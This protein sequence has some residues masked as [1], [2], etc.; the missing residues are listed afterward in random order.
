M[1]GFPNIIDTAEIDEQNVVI[2]KI[3]GENLR[4]VKE[5]QID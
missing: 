2:M 5:K 1:E 4:T 3:L